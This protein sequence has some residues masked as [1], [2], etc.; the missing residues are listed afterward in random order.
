MRKIFEAAFAFGLVGVLGVAVPTVEAGYRDEVLADQPFLYY[1][2]EETSGETAVDSSGNGFDGTYVTLLED[3]FML[4]AEGPNGGAVFFDGENEGYVETP[5]TEVATELWSIE[6]LLSVDAVDEGCCT[7]LFSTVEYPDLELGGAIH[8][9]LE[10]ETSL[11][12]DAPGAGESFIPGAVTVGDD[13]WFHIVVTNDN[14]E[15][16]E[17]VIYID[18][19]LIEASDVE[20][21]GESHFGEGNIAGWVPE[22]DRFMTGTIDEVA[23]YDSILSE[24][25]VQAH[26][27]AIGTGATVD[28]DF[29]KSGALDLADINLLNQEMAAGTNGAEFDL[30]ADNVVD[31]SD[32]KIWVTELKQTWFGDANLDGVFNT[33]DFVD[34]FQ[35]GKFEK[36]EAAGWEE[37]DWNGDLRFNTT[38]FVNAFQDGG[39]E[40]GPRTQ[41]QVVP[42][43]SSALLMPLALACICGWRRRRR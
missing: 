14:A 8:L 18:G 7:S 35:K 2:F 17:R 43:P 22:L 13:E 5:D 34:V 15:E 20:G 16:L 39:F 36:D 27:E 29:D 42:E 32:Q 12:L 19:E 38:D 30:N 25:R 11:L 26:F 40:K 41:A 37:G 1:E 23:F 6:M 28:G 4:G 24:E 9:N 10:E 33:T 3:G 31:E 21:F